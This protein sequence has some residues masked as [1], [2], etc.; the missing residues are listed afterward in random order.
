M[1][2]CTIFWKTLV[3]INMGNK[4]IEIIIIKNVYMKILVW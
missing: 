1:M 4:I 2:V 3:K